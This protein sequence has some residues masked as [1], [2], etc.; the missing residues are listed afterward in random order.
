MPGGW[1]PVRA[2]ALA[3][4]AGEVGAGQAEAL[5]LPLQRAVPPALQA[6]QAPQGLWGGC[7]CAQ[8]GRPAGPPLGQ[9]LPQRAA[10]W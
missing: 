8:S 5:P 4:V 1:G 6:L 7:R 9:Q 3:Q 10:V 2:G